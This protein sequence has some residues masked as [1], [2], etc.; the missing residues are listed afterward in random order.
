VTGHEVNSATVIRDRFEAGQSSILGRLVQTDV[1]IA[2]RKESRNREVHLPPLSV[3]RWWAR[4]TGAVNDAILDAA[5]DHFGKQSLSIVDPFAGGGTIPLVALRAGHRVQAQ[6][7]NPWAVAGMRQ[8][9]NLPSPDVLTSALSDLADAARPVLEAA[10]S[11]IDSGGAPAQVVHTYRVAI[12]ACGDCGEEERLFPYS[13]LTLKSRKER[14]LPAAILACPAGH[15]FHGPTDRLNDCPVCERV[16]DPQALY[17]S[18]RIATCQ[19]CGKRERLSERAARPSW[20]WEPALVERSSELGREFDTPSTAEIAQAEIGWNPTVE[21]PSIPSGVETSVLLRHGFSAWHDLYP[22]R[23]RVVMETLLRLSPE[24][25][26]DDDVAHALRM[27]IVGTAEFAGH[28]C[29]WD[30]FYLKCNDA[31]AGH[32]FNFSTFVPEINVVGAGDIGRGTLRR[33]VRSFNK[34]SNWLKAHDLD[35]LNLATG[36]ARESSCFEDADAQ[37]VLGDS[38]DLGGRSG[39][40]DL[41]LTDPPY[42]DDVQYS[43]LSLLFRSWADLSVG[44]LDGEASTNQVT[45]V[46]AEGSDYGQTLRRIFAECRRTLRDEGRLIFSYANTDPE[47]WVFL[48]SG[49]HAAGLH[50]VACISVHS[51]N[52]TDFK[53]RDV[54]SSVE[55]LLMELSPT[56]SIDGPR[57]LERHR[58][59]PFMDCVATFFESVGKFDQ[60]WEPSA[61]AALTELRAVR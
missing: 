30:R 60:G 20:R 53:K 28:L 54:R 21:L 27:A 29:R 57:V 4:R 50:A 58:L 44:D 19:S 7:I 55:D 6:D 16:T 43:E 45:G 3:F 14:G 42:H 5:S 59:D 35:H 2:A 33:R 38:S 61:V 56:A 32:R 31:T 39:R 12:G 23:Q 34:A 36:P 11:T 9:L 13:L 41:V 26:R 40:F 49:L 51:E 48:L 52:E 10:Y 22:A 25:T 47:A 8:M 46:N 37:L 17:T 18:R 1:S 15:V 24:V